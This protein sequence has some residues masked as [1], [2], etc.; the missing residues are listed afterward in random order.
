MRETTAIRWSV[1]LGVLLTAGLVALCLPTV[2]VAQ[3]ASGSAAG[4]PDRA[5]DGTGWVESTLARMTLTE[6]VGQ[7]FMTYAYGE[8]ADTQ[9][10]ADVANNQATY[11]VDNASQLIDRYQLG[12]VIYFAWSNNVNAPRQ[13]AELSNGVQ[14]ASLRQ[15]RPVPALVSTDQEGGIVARV[16][17]TGLPGNMALGAGRGVDDA[18]TAAVIAGRELDSVGVNWNFAPVADVNVNPANPVI[19]VRSFS[20]DAGLTSDLTAAQVGGYQSEGIAAAAKHFPG[21][22]DTATDSH[23]G[24]PVIDHTEQEWT[25][26]DRPPFRAAIDAGIQAIMTAHI[27]V[28]SLDP[29]GDPATLSRPIMTGILR[30]DMGYDGVVITDALGMAG[31]RQKYG[32]DRVPVLALQAGVDMLLMPPDLDLAYRSV[33]EAVRTGELTER[34]IDTS[35]RRI[36]QLKWELGLVRDPYVD[37]SAVDDVVRTR[38]HLEQAQA[39]TDRT[40]TL[41]K[42]DGDLLPLAS[43]AQHSALV[44][45]W[46]VSTTATIASKMEQRAASA[47][48]LETGTNPSEAQIDAAVAAAQAHDVTVVVSYRAW[49]DGHAG[50]RELIRR[51]TATGKPVIAVAAR[52]AYDVAHYPDVPAYLATY[53]YA[54]VSLESLVR[55]LYGEVSPQGRL[56]V[57]IPTADDPATALY[58]FG[59]GLSY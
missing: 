3:G 30:K 29:S 48:V 10:P 15:R 1:R 58:P 16:P 52:D 8:T 27:V 55:V 12:G 46:G 28:P 53:S 22:G 43:G 21:H 25:Q 7:L 56:P 31:V 40:T 35:V 54:E 14:D 26:I 39:L 20:E 44:T 19:G 59:H 2:V 4:G 11:G 50:Q 23:T 9:A 13:I 5:S 17:A 24:L 51:L 57:T 38:E 37:V 34:R 49:L 6:K 33:L 42:N 45:G 41:V 18:R 36:L 47:D 32:D